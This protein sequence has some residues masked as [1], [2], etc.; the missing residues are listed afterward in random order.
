MT[1]DF[2]FNAFVYLTATVVSVPIAKRLGLGSVLGYLIAGALIGP[3]VFGLVGKDTE[4]VMHFAEFGVVMMLF[5]VGLEL[6]PSLLWRMR[7]PI[8]GLGGLQVLITTTLITGLALAFGLSVTAA[9]AI[10]MTLALSST[11]IVLQ[12]LEEKE[13]LKTPGGQ[14]CF[15]VLLFQDIAVIPMLAILP[16]LGG[17]VVNR[18]SEPHAA[19]AG[20]AA[21][22]HAGETLIANLPGWQQ[23]LAVIGA[24][25]ALIFIGRTVM[26]HVLRSIAAAHLP[27][28]F[29]A[30][31]LLLVIGIALLMQSVGLSPA[32]GT[33]VAGVV[34]ADSEYR[35][36]LEADIQPFK[37]LLL[38]LFFLAV[39][40]GIDFP[41]LG[42]E[43][44]RILGLV[45]LLITVKVIVLA[46]LA[47][48]FKLKG[49]ASTL[50]TF[51]LAQG[52]EFAFV[53]FSFSLQNGVLG[54]ETVSPLVLAVALSMALTP[55]LMIF[56]ERVLQPRFATDKSED[57]APDAIE[58]EHPVVMAGFG[59]FGHIVGLA[60]RTAGIGVNVLDLDGGQIEVL[61]K[62][63]TKVF[64]G[65]ATRVDL[66]HAAG[67]DQAKLFIC[68]IDGESKAVHVVETVRKHFPHLFILA[69]ARGR[70]HAYALLKAGADVVERETTGSSLELATAAL[71]KLGMDPH[72]A[73]RLTRRFRHHDELY[74]REMAELWGNE[75]AYWARARTRIGELEKLL[76]R[77]MAT[78]MHTE[79]ASWE[80]MRDHG[81]RP[82]AGD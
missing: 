45:A 54:P 8:L 29:T 41:L 78:T 79:D 21:E 46:L 82:D 59:R 51:A 4:D 27:E 35:H 31:A 52:G 44:L 23:A 28:V 71:S 14:S 61:R 57:R 53:L 69:R 48:V 43:P 77:D 7:G 9:L 39:G 49:G 26:R 15:A 55:L 38:G 81:P 20:A 36:E 67:C 12:T 75:P 42:A 62:I 47:R 33:F 66:L 13:M 63:G 2:L 25:A 10:G 19:D 6:R 73:W 64:Y 37:G 32:L 50:F 65:D 68:A 80:S 74:V 40:A 11:A 18:S 70:P 24:V 5:L 58:E 72:L 1:G 3:H 34:L 76:K 16:L 56:Q 60:L 22:S 17:Q 30:A